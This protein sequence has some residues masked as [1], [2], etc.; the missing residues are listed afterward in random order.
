[1]NSFDEYKKAVSDLRHAE[2]WKWMIGQRYIGG[3]GGDGEVVS[4]SLSM[5]IYYQEYDGAKNYHEPDKAM[6][7]ALGVAAKKMSQQLID[8]AILELERVVVEKAKAAVDD[9][10]AILAAASLLQSER[11]DGE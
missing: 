6:V 3:G 5:T 11:K 10:N 2:A 1:M 9:A 8:L 4:V 7:D